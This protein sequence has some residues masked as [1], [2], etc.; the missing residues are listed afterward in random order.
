[1]KK[2]AFVNK[3]RIFKTIVENI[4][5][6]IVMAEKGGRIHFMNAAAIEILGDKRGAKADECYYSDDN[7]SGHRRGRT[8]IRKMLKS[9]NGIIKDMPTELKAKDG[10]LLSVNLSASLFQD[11]DGQLIGSVGMIKDLREITSLIDI[12]NS[13]LATH[14]IDDILKRICAECLKLPKSIRAYIKLYDEVSDVLVPAAFRSRNPEEILPHTPTAKFAGMSG[15][16][17]RTQQPYLS[18]DVTKEA[19]ERYHEIFPGVR[20]R[21]VVPVKSIDR[22]TYQPKPLGVIVVE[23][24]VINS[25]RE[26]D[27]FFLSTIATLAATAIENA[28]LFES[29]TKIITELTALQSIRETISRTVNRDEILDNLSDTVT[30]ILGFDYVNISQVDRY[31]RQI[32]T[33]KVRNMPPEFCELAVHSLESEDIQACVARNREEIFLTGWDDRLDRDLYKRFHHENLVRIYMPIIAHEEAYGTVETGYFKSHKTH[34]TEEE[35]E[36]LRKVVNLAGI[37]IDQAFLLTEREMLNG[38]IKALN[39]ASVYIQ[40]SR[41]EKEVVMH[42]FQSLRRIGYEK[43]MLSLVNQATG[44]IEGHF[45]MGENW[46]RIKSETRRPLNSDDILALCIREKRSLLSEDCRSDPRCD[47]KAV[48]KAEIKSQ[49][50]IPLFLHSEPLGALQI[51][52]TDLQG[53]VKGSQ[54]FFKQRMEVLET[55]AHQIA[56]A[57]RNARDMSRIDLL[58]TALIQTAHEFKSPIHNILTEV[59]GL[60]RYLSRSNLAPEEIKQSLSAISDEANRASRQMQNTLMYSD[61]SRTVLGMN[62][63]KQK[64]QYILQ[65][66]VTS[67]KMRGLERGI[68]IIIKDNVKKLPT[69]EFD[70][71]KIEQVLNNLLDNAIKYSHN[72]RYIECQGFDDGTKIH[73]TIWDKG[74]GIPAS[75]FSTIFQGF[76]RSTYKDK[77][78]YIP[79]TGLGLKICKELVEEHGGEITVQSDPFFN[80]PEKIKNYDGYDTKFT[81]ILPKVAKHK[82]H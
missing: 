44:N 50:V 35:R 69:F 52:L 12:G 79:G 1:M 3:S 18:H 36:I 73:L 75:E 48:K 29:K 39:H 77:K 47:Q 65:K 71:N 28:H 11:D 4:A 23:S 64:I 55:F 67:F 70:E 76:T 19:A 42:I 5:D 60:Q 82:D 17:F 37:G 49:Y 57:I 51:D 30:D 56:I 59:G 63:K 14:N 72:N 80:D 22:S 24:E 43:G 13:L 53:L 38:Q 62:I 61:K 54:E 9:P 33:V 8:I 15:F 58:Q 74:Q 2:F 6:P 10:S 26:N 16:V 41:T 27:K 45:A 21:L 68:A 20:S 46:E 40:S 34:I 32:K 25:F 7:M 66:S 81:I 31:R 78:R